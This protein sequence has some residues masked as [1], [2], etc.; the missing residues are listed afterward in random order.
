[1]DEDDEWDELLEART[2]VGDLL[3][4]VT[5]KAEKIE[6]FVNQAGCNAFFAGIF[7]DKLLD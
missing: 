5:A 7:F 4:T 3:R 1:M 2:K 6:V